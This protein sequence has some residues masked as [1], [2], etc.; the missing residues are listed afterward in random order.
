M[1]TKG[2]PYLGEKVVK[3]NEYRSAM[4]DGFLSHF[5]KRGMQR[6]REDGIVDEGELSEAHAKRAVRIMQ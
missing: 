6:G 3:E 2:Q 5:V 4:I 1:G